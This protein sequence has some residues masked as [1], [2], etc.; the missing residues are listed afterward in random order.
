[1][2]TSSSNTPLPSVSL[3]QALTDIIKS[4]A[5]E[6]TTLSSILNLERE[7]IEKAKSGTRNIGEFISIN[8]SINSIIKNVIKLQ[9]LTQIK[10]EYAEELFEKMDRF[11]DAEEQ[12]E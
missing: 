8:E 4:I 5:S 11:D 6:E 7:M 10:L 12:E 3:E 2:L 1:M 9:M